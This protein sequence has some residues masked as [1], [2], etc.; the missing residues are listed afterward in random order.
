MGLE[1]MT[2]TDK[3][4]NDFVNTNPVGA[5]DP[6]SQGDDH[7]RGIKN[8]LINTFPNITGA[9]TATHTELSL[10]EGETAITDA[11]TAD[12]IVKRDSN[13]D[14]SANDITANEVTADLIGNATSA[15]SGD[16]DLA[17]GGDFTAG[18]V[19]WWKVGNMV[20][21]TVE[22]LTWASASTASATA[23]IPAGFRPAVAVAN[24]HGVTTVVLQKLSVN[25]A[26]DIFISAYDWAGATKTQTDGLAG[27]ISFVVA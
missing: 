2:G 9:V 24:L 19:R 1:D 23:V 22:G 25:T 7:L 11:N 14:F 6:K 3:F 18:T 8:V 26:G 12:A 21:V 15:G 17:P 13:G 4:I 10:L 16:V 27:S 5:T 20:T